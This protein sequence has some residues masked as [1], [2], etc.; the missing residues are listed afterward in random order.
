[1]GHG[2]R[3]I[4]WFGVTA[5]PTAEWI[6]NQVREA[7]GWEQAPRY[8]IRDRQQSGRARHPAHRARAQ[9]SSV[10]GLRWRWRPVGNRLLPH[11]HRKTQQCRALC[12]ALRRPAANDR[13][14]SRQPP[15]RVPALELAAF[16]RQGIAHVQEM[17]A[18]RAMAAGPADHPSG[19]RPGASNRQ[20]PRQSRSARPCPDRQVLRSP[21]TLQAEPDLRPARRRDR[22]LDPGELGRRRLQVAGAPAGPPSSPCVWLNQVVCRRHA[23]SGARSRPRPHQDR[24]VVGLCT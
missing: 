5:H 4:L 17:D 14:S 1:M 11:R 2:R 21:A 20:G 8:L 7:C 6:A 18:Y 3:Q 16:K 10:R 19:P 12:L 13:R 24:P 23:D 9:K 22:A 15:R